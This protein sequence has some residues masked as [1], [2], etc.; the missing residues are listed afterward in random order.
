MVK[1]RRHAAKEVAD[2]ASNGMGTLLDLIAPGAGCAEE[3]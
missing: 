1:I 2:G 3:G